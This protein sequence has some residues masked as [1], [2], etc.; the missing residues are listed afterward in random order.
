MKKQTDTERLKALD[1]QRASVLNK[2]ARADLMEHDIVFQNLVRAHKSLHAIIASA[3]LVNSTV[4]SCAVD[5][6]GALEQEITSR[7]TARAS[8]QAV[9]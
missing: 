9:K 3:S 6:S 2:I 4:Q 1:E 8:E 5:L 7:I